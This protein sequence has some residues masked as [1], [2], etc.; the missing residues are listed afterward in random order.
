MTET[1]LSEDELVAI[2]QQDAELWEQWQSA[3]YEAGELL[4]IRSRQ[5]DV[6][7][8][9]A[10]AYWHALQ[11]QVYRRLCT[12]PTQQARAGANVSSKSQ[13]AST[14]LIASVTDEMARATGLSVMK[15]AP[16]VAL[17]FHWAITLSV[18]V[19]CELH[20]DAFG[21]KPR[22]KKPKEPNPPTP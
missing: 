8:A 6:N 10:Q 15:L 7:H 1:Y 3:S 2:I 17:A 16:F 22:T 19:W 20:A 21:E 11:R 4:D 12:T 5:D 14:I 18:P 13:V 9:A